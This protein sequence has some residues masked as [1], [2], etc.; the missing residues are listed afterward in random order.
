MTYIGGAAVFRYDPMGF[1]TIMSSS[2]VAEMDG[3][4]FWMG[5]DRFYV[6]D[7]RVQELSN[8][9]NINWVFDNLNFDQR[10]KVWA[11]VVPRWGEIW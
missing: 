9:M 4:F 2:G 3:Y 11:T 6:Y 1:S 10:Q 7:G 8:Q 5:L